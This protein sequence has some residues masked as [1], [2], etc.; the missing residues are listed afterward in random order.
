MSV[1]LLREAVP[2]ILMIIFVPSSLFTCISTH[3]HTEV[4]SGVRLR[5]CIVEEHKL[6]LSTFVELALNQ[7]LHPSNFTLVQWSL[8]H[9]DSGMPDSCF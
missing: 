6:M 8:F 1:L 9:Q 7:L 3:V 2:T 5:T 4:A